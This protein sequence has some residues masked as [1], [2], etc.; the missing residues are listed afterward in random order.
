MSKPP[1]SKSPLPPLSFSLP[2]EYANMSVEKVEKLLGP[3][4]RLPLTFV[5]HL[6]RK[7]PDPDPFVLDAAR[8]EVFEHEYHL[9][10]LEVEKKM[11]EASSA[12]NPNA[13]AGES[14][15]SDNPRPP[16]P[17]GYPPFPITPEDLNDAE[18]QVRHI[19]MYGQYRDHIEKSNAL[20]I[21]ENHLERLQR[22]FAV[23]ERDF[24]EAYKYPHYNTDH[25][26][27]LS[28]PPLTS[29]QRSLYPPDSGGKSKRVKRSKRSNR[30]KRSKTCKNRVHKRRN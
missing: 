18:M 17:R 11:R 6:R 22:Q 1:R 30:S 12:P 13:N 3:I 9:R 23:Q 16:R 29:Y 4:P 8:R 14:H 21:A 28:A 5:E 15:T 2:P 24:P 19:Q 7:T 26:Y 20:R 27:A 25:V 10:R